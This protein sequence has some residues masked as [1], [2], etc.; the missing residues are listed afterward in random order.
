M[1]ELKKEANFMNSEQSFQQVEEQI[2]KFE[3]IDSNM[4][5]DKHKTSVKSAVQYPLKQK[6]VQNEPNFKTLG[7]ISE[8]DKIQIIKTRIIG[9][10]VYF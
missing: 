7:K 6:P 8:D 2:H 1:I 5:S 10:K 4:L 3:K 9:L